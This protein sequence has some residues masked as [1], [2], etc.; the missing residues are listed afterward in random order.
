MTGSGGAFH[1]RRIKRIW[2]GTL[3]GILIG[4]VSGFGAIVFNFLLQT[5]TRF[6]MEDLVRFILPASR[7]DVFFLGVPLV[8]WVAIAF[9]A[10]GGLIAGLI[11][12]NF[13]PEAEGHGTDAM[14]DSF[15]RKK[16]V[17]RR[18]VPIIKTIA[19]AITIGSGGSA[20]KEGPIAQIGAGFGSFLASVLKVSD[21]E[22][23]I[24]APCRGSGRDRRHLQG[25]AWVPP[26][27]RRKCSTARRISSSRPSSLHPLFHRRLHGLHFF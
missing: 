22:R 16:G 10:I 6:F 20:G 14:I 9:P 24:D 23:R 1:P 27:S 18:R 2:R 7:A 8:R 11:V 3:I 12:F 26:S 15:H 19:S 17:I 21:R 13:A 4:V 5:S 25:P